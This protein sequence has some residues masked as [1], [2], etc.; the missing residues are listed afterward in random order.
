MEKDFRPNMVS[1]L[2]LSKKYFLYE[3]PSSAEQWLEYQKIRKEIT[4]LI[5][6][7]LSNI[8]SD[9]YEEWFQDWIN[10]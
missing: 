9:W 3:N 10:N 5:N 1:I 4:R 6:I 2:E 7:E 8:Y